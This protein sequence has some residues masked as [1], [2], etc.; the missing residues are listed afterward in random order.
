MVMALLIHLAPLISVS[1]KKLPDIDSHYFLNRR[2]SHRETHLLGILI[3]LVLS[4]I[5]GA[6][7]VFLV[8]RGVIF[9]DF[10]YISILFFGVLVWFGKGLLVTPLLGI[11]FFGIKEGKMVWLEM[12]LIHQVYA[13]MFW[14]AIHLYV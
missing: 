7:Y 9:H 4:S 8:D 1:G 10:H 6:L 14:L 5:F 13:L 2:F 12:F 11:G 3:Q